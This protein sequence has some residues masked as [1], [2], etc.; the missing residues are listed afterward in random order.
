MRI[1]VLVAMLLLGSHASRADVVLDWADLA[2]DCVRND[3]TGPTVSTRN[4][5]I[6]HTAIYDAVNSIT[7]THQS[8][9]FQLE[10]PQDCSAE[11]AVVGAAYAVTTALYPSYAPL[12]QDLLNAYKASASPGA[13]MT[14]GL[15]FG[16]WM[17][18]FA[19]DSRG[20][21]GANTDVPYTPSNLPGQWQRTPPFF[22]PPLT[23]NWRY[24]DLFC[25]PG[26]EAFMPAPPPALNSSEYAL[27]FNEVKRLGAAGTTNRTPEQSEIAVFWSDFSHTAMPPGHWHE[28]GAA[29]ARSRTNTLEEN[30]RL[31]A[32]IS[33][34]QADA[35]I[36]C[37]EAKYR[38]NLWRPVT[39]IQRADEDGNPAT[40]KDAT[41]NHYLAAPPFPAYT[42]GHSTF[43]KASAQVLA[44]FYGTDAI[45]FTAFS[46][47]LPGIAR[48]FTSLSICADEVG[49]S[50][51]FGGIHF[52]FDHV[53]GKLTGQKIGDYI[54]ANFLLPNNRLP[55]A[56]IEGFVG[57]RP[58][59]RLHGRA[60]KV[61]VLE[62]SPDL[63]AWTAVSTNL[64]VSGGMVVQDDQS[65][66]AGARFYRI[67]EQ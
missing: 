2:L 31:F 36:V 60:G 19:L 17:G 63:I 66:T 25:L 12:A 21:D 57:D 10:P 49:M 27:A 51:I 52:R 34:A 22:R 1:R 42:S 7:R 26:I 58:I 59:L 15:N 48:S 41:W 3:N 54:S 8:Y 28:I 14:N 29:I 64:V 61:C 44:N 50:R 62:M 5:A 18:L 55:E 30:A 11:A 13:A 6:L 53:A 45:A 24:V 32:L 35:A 65:A 20:A 67:R 47:S 39:A 40:E 33:L 16:W 23:P 38:N 4:L 46:D 9:R 56:R 37:W 43:S